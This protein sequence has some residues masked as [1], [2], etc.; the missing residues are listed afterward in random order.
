[1]F[2]NSR[3][4]V[5]Q[6]C[7]NSSEPSVHWPLSCRTNKLQDP[8]FHWRISESQLGQDASRIDLH[9]HRLPRKE[10]CSHVL[11][12][13]L[14]IPLGSTWASAKLTSLPWPLQVSTNGGTEINLILEKR[15]QGFTWDPSSFVLHLQR[16]ITIHRIT[17]SRNNNPQ[18]ELCWN[19]LYYTMR[20]G[21]G[22]A[23]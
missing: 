11:H 5:G 9:K 19:V 4:S 7:A 15:E 2:P 23:L 20:N 6:G 1:M 10:P 13:Y 17:E 21:D 18:V 22:R 3:P 16:A 8:E 14:L 12:L